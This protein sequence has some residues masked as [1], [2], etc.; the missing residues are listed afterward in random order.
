MF[1]RG[2]STFVSI[3]GT[4]EPRH[5]LL[6]VLVCCSFLSL[7]LLRTKR[8]EMQIDGPRNDENGD[9]IAARQSGILQGR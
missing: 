1:R 7:A 3:A 6:L 5:S 2:T 9:M 4:L 8:G